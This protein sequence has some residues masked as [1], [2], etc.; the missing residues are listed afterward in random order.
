MY[1]MKIQRADLSQPIPNV[2]SSPVFNVCNI[3]KLGELGPGDEAIPKRPYM[4][5]QTM[6]M[7]E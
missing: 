3:K 2:A 6:Q 5:K 4:F 7:A 1:R